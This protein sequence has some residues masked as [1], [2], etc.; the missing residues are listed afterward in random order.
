MVAEVRQLDALARQW[1][2]RYRVIITGHTDAD[3]PEER[4]LALSRER[5]AVVVHALPQQDLPSLVFDARG[6]G[7]AEPLTSGTT[8]A[9]K[10]RNRR[11]AVRIEPL[12]DQ[13][14]P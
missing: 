6:V 12:A 8:D 10:Q 3:G 4:N 11:V 1:G 5:S 9:D 2:I 13:A 7:S 14:Q